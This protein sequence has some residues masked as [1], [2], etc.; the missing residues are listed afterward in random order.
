MSGPASK[1]TT[2]LA[3]ILQLTRESQTLSMQVT[4]S[5]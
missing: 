3:L 5:L 4:V 2:M 1:I